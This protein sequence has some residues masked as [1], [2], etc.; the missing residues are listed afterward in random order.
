MA[1]ELKPGAFL[2]LFAELDAEATRRSVKT[3][4]ELALTVEKQAKINASNGAHKYGTPTPARPGEGPAVISGNLRRAITHTSVRT[5]A[6]GFEVMVGT[7]VGFPS[8][9]GSK[10]PAGK[11]GYYLEVKGL[12]NGAKYPF[13]QPAFK[14]TM[15]V[16]AQL[17]YAKNFGTGWKALI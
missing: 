8:T 3:L 15:G 10:T 1:S 2:K 17:I 7:A 11:Y 14:F 5:T 4:T 13:L 9:Y 16:P 12:V 6:T